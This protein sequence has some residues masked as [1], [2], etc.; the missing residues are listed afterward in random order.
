MQHNIN[1]S[2]EYPDKG[3]IE[4]KLHPDYAKTLGAKAIHI[5]SLLISNNNSITDDIC[6]LYSEDDVDVV[7]CIRVSDAQLIGHILRNSNDTEVCE[8]SLPDWVEFEAD[9]ESK[10]YICDLGIGEILGFVSPNH[11]R[12]ELRLLL[13]NDVIVSLY[14]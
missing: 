6:R 9:D 13:D 7:D 8:S 4:C 12:A 10:T 2:Y 5:L 3:M 14:A 11:D 1:F